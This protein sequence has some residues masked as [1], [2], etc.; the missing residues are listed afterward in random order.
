MQTTFKIK[1]Y[2]ISAGHALPGYLVVRHSYTG[3]PGSKNLTTGANSGL[4]KGRSSWALHDQ[5]TLGSW[6]SMHAC[7]IFVLVQL[8]VSAH[9]MHELTFRVG[10]VA[11]SCSGMEEAHLGFKLF[12][13]KTKEETYPMTFADRQGARHR[14]LFNY[15]RY[16]DS[17]EQQQH[18]DLLN[19]TIKQDLVH[20]VLGASS[21][22]ALSDSM[23]ANDAQRIIYHCC[24]P[25]DSLY[26]RDMK[27]VFG[28][29]SSNTLQPIEALKAMALGGG[30]K[31]LYIFSL[32]DE[33][34]FSTCQAAADFAVKSLALEPG[35][36]LV[37]FTVYTRE[38]ATAHPA[39]YEEIVAEAITLRA[40][41]AMGCDVE[42][43]G[44]YV[45]ELFRSSKHRLKALWLAEAPTNSQFYSEAG[46]A[47]FENIL[48]AAQWAPGLALN[49]GLFG[50]A[51]RYSQVFEELYGE[52]PSDNSASASA[53]LLSLGM[54]ISEAFEGC[55]FP[56]P[57]LDADR[58]LFEKTAIKCENALGMPVVTNGYVWL[59]HVLAQQKLNTF[60]GKVEFNKFRRNAAKGSV[61][62]Q[63]QAGKF[64]VVLPLEV[65]NK[66]LVMPMPQSEVHDASYASDEAQ[67]PSTV[68]SMYK[69]QASRLLAQLLHVN[70]VARVQFPSSAGCAGMA[71]QNWRPFVCL[72]SFACPGRAKCGHIIQSTFMSKFGSLRVL[73]GFLALVHLLRA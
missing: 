39:L 15:T 48:T 70:K 10:L 47:G 44:V 11:G 17:C 68:G 42:D 51:A 50:S 32:A 24:L 38:N 40:D 41:A 52:R 8:A 61:T 73:C 71:T 63:V 27:H 55:E 36:R 3:L 66:K 72:M 19:R 4:G 34:M 37:R 23:S 22:F 20:F 56:D 43:A 29:Q 28:I 9:A 1:F 7:V 35:F 16:D 60:F 45:N 21:Q 31:R 67:Q 69:G 62:L 53:T 33:L 59:Q 18:Q 6:S 13:D 65:A 46:G 57:D 49:D 25:S 30:L 64:E 54:A 12:A 2:C 5:T 58:L 14:I 26:R